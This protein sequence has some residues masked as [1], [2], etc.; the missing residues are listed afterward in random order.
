LSHKIDIKLKSLVTKIKALQKTCS[1]KN[2]K[3]NCRAG[4]DTLISKFKWMRKKVMGLEK[5]KADRIKRL[6]NEHKRSRKALVD[7]LL[8]LKKKTEEIKKR[9]G[10]KSACSTFKTDPI[11]YKCFDNVQCCSGFTKSW[12]IKGRVRCYPNIYFKIEK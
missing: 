12:L 2:S 3:S 4:L 11:Y 6:L 1:K 8:R 10:K 9:H 7:E 5:L